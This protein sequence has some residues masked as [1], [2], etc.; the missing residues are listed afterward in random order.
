[1]AE[2]GRFTKLQ[3]AAE[4]GVSTR[5]VDNWIT[6]GLLRP[7]IKLGTQPQS[8]VR[9]SAEQLAELDE[10]LALLGREPAPLRQQQQI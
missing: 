3:V 10:R 7:P 5:T 8:R 6:R 2:I 4:R 1:M 9:F